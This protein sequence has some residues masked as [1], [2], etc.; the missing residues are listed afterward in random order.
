MTIRCFIAGCTWSEGVATLMGKGIILCQRCS[1]C[2][3]FRYVA[4]V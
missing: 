1:C 4:E 2:G 3:S